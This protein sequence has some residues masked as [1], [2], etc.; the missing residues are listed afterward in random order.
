MQIE[1]A[2]KKNQENLKKS[3][4]KANKGEEELKKFVDSFELRIQ[5]LEKLNTLAKTEPKDNFH[6]IYNL[7]EMIKETNI[8]AEKIEIAFKLQLNSIK[9]SCCKKGELYNIEE[10]QAILISELKRLQV[11]TISVQA[12]QKSLSD[13]AILMQRRKE[14]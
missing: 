12:N 4:K 11:Q 13:S 3:E 14:V 9:K 2:N 10:K 5:H 8:K 7:E 1:E 6:E